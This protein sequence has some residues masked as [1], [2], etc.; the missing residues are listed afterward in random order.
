MRYLIFL[1]LVVLA[2]ACQN[3]AE[4]QYRVLADQVPLHETAGLKSRETAF[5]KKGDRVNDLGSVSPF[6]SVIEWQGKMLQSP[7]IKVET[8]GKQ[9][10]VLA[11]FLSPPELEYAVW[12]DR[13]RLQSY[14][15]ESL[16]RRR[17]VWLENKAGQGTDVQ[18]AQSYLE[19]LAL[20]D[21]FM[22]ILADRAE[23]VEAASAPDYSWLGSLL[24]GFIMQKV[25][26][27]NTP[28]LFADYN[29]WLP[30]ATASTGA[31][32][33]LFFGICAEMFPYDKVESFFPAWRFQLDE[34]N[35]AS[36]LGSGIHLKLLTDIEQKLP[37][38]TAFRPALLRIRSKI[39]DDIAGRNSGYWQP[40]EKI[41]A[42]LKSILEINFSSLPE[43]EQIM[44]QT[45]FRMFEDPEANGI[46]VNLRSG[47]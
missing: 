24:P 37:E 17:E 39:L 44:L 10:W 41:L 28:Y 36:Q 4:G 43:S 13:I 8:N 6:E 21:T 14:F 12:F 1:L 27:R 38:A 20:R 9:G 35:S 40:E 25:P 16:T 22:S 47:E 33:E 42:E 46:R 31:Q 18:L 19:A 11:A 7:W 45:R 30:K 32:D 15:G 5:L 34:S 2:G 29:Y 26:L 23:T 3:N